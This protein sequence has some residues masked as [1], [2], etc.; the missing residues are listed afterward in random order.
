LGAE[1]HVSRGALRRFELFWAQ[2]KPAG[3]AYD[4]DAHHIFTRKAA[5][6]L[7]RLY[8]KSAQPAK[9]EEIINWLA[10]DDRIR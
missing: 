4:D 10:S 8:A 2:H 5:Y 6:A 1:R 7:A 3:R 9:C